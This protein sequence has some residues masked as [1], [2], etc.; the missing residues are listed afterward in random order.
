[1]CKK[2]FTRA[3]MKIAYSDAALVVS[4]RD[5]V[6]GDEFQECFRID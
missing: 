2:A 5:K 1:M 6:L 3:E 4:I